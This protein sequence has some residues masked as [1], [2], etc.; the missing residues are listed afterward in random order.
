MFFIEQG[1]RVA[2]YRPDIGA[3][4]EAAH[5][6]VFTDMENGLLGLALDP[7]FADNGWLYLMRS[8]RH[9]P[10]QWISRFTV[11]GDVLDRASEKLVF[12]FE[13]QRDE[14]CR[15]AGSLE[16]GP[17]G[18]LFIATGD[19]TNPFGSDGYG[20]IDE[21]DGRSPWDG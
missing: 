8:P 6:P 2:V 19:N 1:G 9:Y 15:H 13:E 3:V 18:E 11:V 12:A 17:G 20:P 16:F 5:F 21:R 7:D 4:V 14:C 10:G